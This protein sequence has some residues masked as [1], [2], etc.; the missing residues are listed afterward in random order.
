LV[1]GSSRPRQIQEKR[2]ASRGLGGETGGLKKNI[3]FLKKQGRTRGRKKFRGKWE[4]AKGL[5]KLWRPLPQGQF[6]STGWDN[7]FRA[8]R[9]SDKSCAFTTWK[10]KRHVEKKPLTE[11]KKT[12]GWGTGVFVSIRERKR[13]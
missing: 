6:K 2:N 1:E 13:G 12:V 10:E 5:F 9:P 7:H 8:E 3:L 4:G 11:K